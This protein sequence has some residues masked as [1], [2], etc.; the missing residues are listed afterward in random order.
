MTTPERVNETGLATPGPNIRAILKM[1]ETV[2]LAPP[3]RCVPVGSKEWFDEKEK[4]IQKLILEERRIAQAE[5]TQKDKRIA[6]LTD[7]N[8]KLRGRGFQ[9]KPDNR[10]KTIA[11]LTGEVAVKTEALEEAVRVFELLPNR[12]II[13]SEAE[14]HIF[15]AMWNL[16]RKALS[17]KSEAGEVGG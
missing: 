9:L 4:R 3:Y 7:E 12:P 14:A 6:E 2:D 11:S 13:G 8:H 15:A 5:L 17:V 16:C 10:D 1:E